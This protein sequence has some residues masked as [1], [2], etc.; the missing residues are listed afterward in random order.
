MRLGERAGGL[1]PGRAQKVEILPVE[2]P[3]IFGRRK[4]DQSEQALAVKQR[5]ADPGA[6]FLQ[7]PLRWKRDAILRLR[8]A[9]AQGI[10][11][12]DPAAGLERRP[13]IA[14]PVQ[15]ARGRVAS[16]PVPRRCGRDRSRG[17]GCEKQAAGRFENVREGFHHALAERFVVRPGADRRRKAQPFR[18]IVVAMLEEMF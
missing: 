2:S 12:D 15:F 14:H 3:A 4:Q 5:H 10:Q 7:H 18:A 6:S 13:E 17:I 8:P 11:L 16:G 1:A 9:V